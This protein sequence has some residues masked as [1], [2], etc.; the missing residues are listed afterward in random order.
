MLD[1]VSS[2]QSGIGEMTSYF[3]E[4]LYSQGSDEVLPK[5]MTNNNNQFLKMIDRK[6]HHHCGKDSDQLQSLKRPGLLNESTCK[7]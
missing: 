1:G 4:M 3:G 5:D 6:C 2:F 7:A